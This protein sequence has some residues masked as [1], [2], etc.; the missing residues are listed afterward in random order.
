MSK[1]RANNFTKYKFQVLNLMLENSGWE[2]KK[3]CEYS[4][5]IGISKILGITVYIKQFHEVMKNSEFL[6]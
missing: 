2:V 3:I 5:F 6:E 4:C 1:A